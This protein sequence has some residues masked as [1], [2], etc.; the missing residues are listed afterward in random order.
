MQPTSCVCVCVCVSV[1]L[2]GMHV[3]RVHESRCMCVEMIAQTWVLGFT[4]HLVG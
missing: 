1:S 3:F 2:L 4:F